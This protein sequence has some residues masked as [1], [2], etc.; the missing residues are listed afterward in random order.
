M[1]PSIKITSQDNN[2]LTFTLS[3][4]DVSF[5]NGLRRTIISDIPIVVFKTFPHEQN[6]ANII[7]NTSRL[8]NELLKQRLSCIPVCISD[9]TIPLN[10]LILEVDEE[11]KSGSEQK[12]HKYHRQRQLNWHVN[13]KT[14]PKLQEN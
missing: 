5:A 11:K 12:R 6:K 7:H 3:G 10:N 13:I 4:V 14:I 9:L 8:N 2:S 1:N